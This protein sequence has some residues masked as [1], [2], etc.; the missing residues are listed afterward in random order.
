[1]PQACVVAG[2]VTVL[3][4]MLVLLSAW[5]SVVG[6]WFTLV[7]RFRNRILIRLVSFDRVVMLLSFF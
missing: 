1:M 3:M 5:T 2:S 6:G 7:F 4:G